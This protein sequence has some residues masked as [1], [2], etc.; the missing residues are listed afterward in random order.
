MAKDYV[1]LVSA[2]EKDAQHVEAQ[3]YIAINAGVLANI[4]NHVIQLVYVQ[5]AK[6]LVIIAPSAMG[7]GNVGSAKDQ[8]NVTNAMAQEKGSVLFAMAE[9]EVQ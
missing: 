3:V 2:Q 1:K 7:Q 9:E 5:I 4:A 8:K 6:E